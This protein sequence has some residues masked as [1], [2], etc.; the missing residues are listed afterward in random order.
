MNS[1]GSSL[2][3]KLHGFCYMSMFS[4]MDTDTF[5]ALVN[6]RQRELQ[7]Q[8]KMDT[9]WRRGVLRQQVQCG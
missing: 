4:E 8:A 7:Q 9:L 3:L 6:V 1:V 2:R 5:L